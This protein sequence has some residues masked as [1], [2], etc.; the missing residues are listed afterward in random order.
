MN[1]LLETPP[2]RV[3]GRVP[4]DRRDQPEHA[5]GAW[6]PAGHGLGYDAFTRQAVDLVTA[7]RAAS[8]RPSFADEL[9]VQRCWTRSSGPHGADRST[10]TDVR[11]AGQAGGRPMTRP[12]TLFTGQ[13]ADLLIE[14]V[15]RLAARG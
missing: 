15:A 2:G 6:W 5:Y 1:V 12:I 7:S 14:E 11:R 4:A 10:W 13:W 9:L 8:P 3:G